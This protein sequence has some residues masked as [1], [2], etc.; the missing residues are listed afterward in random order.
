MHDPFAIESSNDE[1]FNE[2]QISKPVV[3]TK[4]QSAPNRLN[5]EKFVSKNVKDAIELPFGEVDLDDILKTESKDDTKKRT[6]IQDSKFEINSQ[7]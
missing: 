3:I 2:P 5:P 7:I 6:Q 4:T 1:S